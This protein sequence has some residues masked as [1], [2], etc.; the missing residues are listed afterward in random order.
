MG[1]KPPVVYVVWL[2][3][4]APDADAS[5]VDATGDQPEPSTCRSV[6]FLLSETP[7]AI[8]IAHTEDDGEAI[9]RFVLVRSAIVSMNRLRL[10][11]T[12]RK[13]PGGIGVGSLEGSGDR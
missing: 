12:H 11:G 1:K 4:C 7:E 9:G 10:P 6:G 2:D 13:R 5:W 8:V 3:H